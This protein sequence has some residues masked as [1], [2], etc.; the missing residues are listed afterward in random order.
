MLNFSKSVPVKKQTNLHLAS[1]GDENIFSIHFWVNYSFNGPTLTKS[2]S[3]RSDQFNKVKVLIKLISLTIIIN[4]TIYSR[5]N[6]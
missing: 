3:F 5:I 6:K 4:T 1:P 2:K